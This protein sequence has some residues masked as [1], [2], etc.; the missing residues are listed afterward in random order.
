M[1]GSPGGTGIIICGDP[2]MSGNYRQDLR[3]AVRMLAKSPGFTITAVATLALGIGA[4]ITIFSA[5]NAVLFRSLPYRDP[6][7]LVIATNAHGQNRQPFS[8]F[9]AGFIADQSKSL[10]GLSTF[11]SE[12]FALTGRG[13]PEQLSG[14]RVG[15]NFFDLLG[16]KPLAGRLFTRQDDSPGSGA[17][18]LISEGLWKRRF[19]GDTAIIGRPVRLNS[20]DTTILGVLPAGF[21]FAPAGRDIDVWS[22]RPFA[23]SGL[24]AEEVRTGQ[25]GVLGLARIRDSVPLEQAQAEMK[26]LDA[27]YLR[28]HAAMYDARPQLNVSLSPLQP[29][30]VASVRMPVLVLFCGVGCVLLIACANV[31]NLLLSR[32]MTRRKEIAVRTALGAGRGAIMLELLSENILLSLLSGA[33]GV[34]LSVWGVRVLSALPASTLPRINPIRIDGQ[35]L[36]FALVLSLVTGLLFGMMP[37]MQV[38]RTDVQ[39]VLREEGRAVA[40]GRRRTFARAGLVICQVALSTILLVAASLLIRT[41]ANLENVPLGFNPHN[42]LI[43]DITLPDT[44][45]APSAF[46]DRLLSEVVALPGVQS[47]GVSS[48]LPLK[49]SHYA[50]ILAEGRQGLPIPQRPNHSVQTVSPSYFETLSI[51]LLRGRLFDSRD[52][53]GSQPV[54]IVN[55]SFVR[56]FWPNDSG[57]GKRIWVGEIAA[58]VE[59]IG[60]VAD[61]KNIRLAVESVPEVYYTTAQHPYG[62][63]HLMLRS[64]SD[65]SLLSG[66]VRSRVAALDREQP[67]TNVRTMDDYLAASISQ[68]RYTMMLL[69]V[70]SIVAL[71]VAAV[72]LYGLVAYSVTQRRQE[73]G[74]R[75]ALGAESGDVI[76]LVMRQGVLAA[77]LGVL[78]GV[79]GSLA[80]TRLLKSMLFGVSSTDPATFVI[81]ALAFVGVAAVASY[82]PARS[83]ARLDPADTLRY[84]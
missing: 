26:V 52:R 51:A 33:L 20:V 80:L 10:E 49:P 36:I 40:G 7:R 6:D 77:F 23:E 32:V 19:N 18:A 2:Q 17:A 66:A 8:Y 78:A 12:S 25:A 5:A 14:M 22:S 31:A 83:A 74:I 4:N 67:V 70:F 28:D 72:G 46:F 56:R 21:E 55:N 39:T 37:T 57:V 73:L 65:P 42:L 29:L 15:W 68:S 48:A 76:R 30:M 27:Q 41:V 79:A 61:I 9:R 62:A 54:A 59:V 38:S 75:L 44:Q 64:P 43:M 1:S 63:M 53:K 45:S 84:E 35:V 69:A 58:P 24:T 82:I 71:L 16:V 81:S 60:V 11:V 3:Y 47:A 13:E 50:S 34:L